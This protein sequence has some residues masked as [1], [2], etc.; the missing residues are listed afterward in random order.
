MKRFAKGLVVLNILA[1]VVTAVTI[2]LLGR[3]SV[4]EMLDIASYVGLGMG[5][6]GA[7]MFVGSTS[8]LSASTGIAASAA[9]QPSRIMDA[10]WGDRT[11]GIST[12]SLFVLGGIIWLGIA[13]LLAGLF[14]TGA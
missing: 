8:G 1:F 13:W 7:L 2:W 9:D 10:L 5:A 3:S 14:G 12:G 11:S 6:V 4:A